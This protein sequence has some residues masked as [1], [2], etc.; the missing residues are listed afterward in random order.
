MQDNFSSQ[1]SFK[2]TE[3]DSK[4]NLFHTPPP[5]AN[6]VGKHPCCPKWGFSSPKTGNWNQAGVYQVWHVASPSPTFTTLLWKMLPL[7]FPQ[8]EIEWSQYPCKCLDPNG[9]SSLTLT[10]FISPGRRL[11]WPKRCRNICW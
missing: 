2:N 8:M 4:G 10:Y 9:L 7:P 11:G 6:T 1:I 5:F 3:T